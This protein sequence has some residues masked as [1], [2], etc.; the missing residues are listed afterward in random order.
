[1]NLKATCALLIWLAPLASPLLPSQA[2]C[3]SAC[4]MAGMDACTSDMTMQACS[5]MDAEEAPHAVPAVVAPQFRSDAL[6]ATS[7]PTTAGTSMSQPCALSGRAGF[8][9]GFHPPQFIPLLI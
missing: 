5:G 7:V 1:M 4:C 6:H 8:A 2:A 9:R 3:E